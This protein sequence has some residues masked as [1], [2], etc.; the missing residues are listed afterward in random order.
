[1]SHNQLQTLFKPHEL[2]MYQPYRVVDFCWSKTDIS[3][4]AKDIIYPI[5]TTWNPELMEST[6]FAY[7]QAYLF[8]IT[9][10]SRYGALVLPF[11]SD[12]ILIY[13]EKI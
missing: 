1:M 10:L 9:V 8:E 11:I 5:K 2:I 13:F 4:K 6:A 7:S 12:S 3:L